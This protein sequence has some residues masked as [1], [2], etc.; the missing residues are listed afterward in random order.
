MP[1]QTRYRSRL[2]NSTTAL[3]AV[4]ALAFGLSGA[5]QA[6]S[7]PLAPQTKLRVT[8]VQWMP[9]KGAYEQWTP[10]G[11][12]FTVSEA[13]TIVLPV[14][15]T[16]AVDS[17]DNAAL[18]AK[19]ADRLQQKIGLVSKPDTTVEVLEYPPIYVV[20]DVTTPGEHQFRTGLTVLQ[21]LALSGG[22]LRT[23]DPGGSAGLVRLIGD[24]KEIEND[25]LRS[26][27]RLARLQAEM[28]GAKEIRFPQTPIETASD[29]TSADIFA[30][31]RI[32][33]TAR[34]NELYRQ[35]KSLGELRDLL[36]AEIGVLQEKIKTADDSIKSAESELAS[37]S[38]LVEK[39]IVVASRKTDLERLLASYRTDRLDQV[40]A[41]MRAR[42]GITEA[43]RNI[44][45][46]RD[47]Q[48]TD[49]AAELQTEQAKLE[50]LTLKRNIS[51][52]LLLDTLAA[53][54]A[55]VPGQQSTTSFAI[56]RLDN[57]AP[58]QIEAQ[59]TTVLQPG[60]VVKVTYKQ[61]PGSD[62]AL[63]QV[64]SGSGAVAAGASQ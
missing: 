46:L 19:I 52:R 21:A 61:A 26:T 14:V 12:E 58:K 17:L 44:D 62:R 40:T 53:P 27:A 13:G 7:V 23:V 48:Q 32:L 15:G 33:F 6:E 50:E 25:M 11:G 43:T 8:V 24:L 55:K 39:G 18:A 37:V 41:V 20:G 31:E 10:L 63:S 60:D 4:A 16:I 56:T 5:A 34:G 36:T 3:L 30:Q 42:Q 47:K 35:T 51:Q 38:Q 29:Q 1:K 54:G 64:I 57:G 49:I 22:E 28:S 59:E 9:T 45:G 2:R